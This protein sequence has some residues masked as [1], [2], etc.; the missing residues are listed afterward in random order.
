MDESRLLVA[1]S[2]C[3]RYSEVESMDQRGNVARA[4]FCGCLSLVGLACVTDRGRVHPPLGEVDAGLDDSAEVASKAMTP[5]GWFREVSLTAGLKVRRRVQE[6][7][8]LQ[9][10]MSGGVCVFDADG[11]GRLDLFFPSERSARTEGPRLYLSRGA[12]LH[13]DDE[14]KMRGLETMGDARG[15]LAF[16]VDGDGAIDL[17]TTGFGGARLFHNEAGGWSA[18]PSGARSFS[19]TCARSAVMPFD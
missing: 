2:F 19:K 18:P 16:D 9:G 7:G 11:D 6:Y 15:C 14:T 13:Y 17:L 8:T 10:R 4:V 1:V 12:K 3:Q 5:A